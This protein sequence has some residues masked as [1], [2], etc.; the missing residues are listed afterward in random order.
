M[1][2]PVKVM[3]IELSHPITTIE[4]LSAYGF[5]KGLVRIHGEPI[6]Y[7]TVPVINGQCTPKVLGKVILEK[8]SKAIIHHLLCDGLAMSSQPG[9]LRIA[10]LFAVQHPVYRG[11]QPLVTVAV[12]TRDR[13][14]DLAR[15]L[16]SLNRLDYAN[17]DILVVDN[18]PD[19][20]DTER[21]VRTTYPN[22]RYVCEPRP[23][24][25]WARNRAIIEARGEI[26]AYTDDDVLVDPGWVKA[27]VTVFLE[28][29]EAMA[30]TGL[31][32]PYEL[33]TE[34]QIFF[35]LLG[36]FGRGFKRKWYQINQEIK[37]STASLY[38]LSWIFGTGANMAF[39]RCLFNQIGYFDPALDVGTVTNG[40]GDLEIFFRVMK[41]GYTMVYEPCALVFHCHRRDYKQLKKQING[42]GTGFC[43]YLIRSALAYPDERFSFLYIGLRWIWRQTRGLLNSFVRH[44]L[45]PRVLTLAEL[46]GFFIGP[47]RYKKALRTAAKIKRDFGPLILTTS[48]K[49]HLLRKTFINHHYPVAE[50]TIDLNNPLHALTDVLDS[51]FVRV[52]VARDG[53]ILGSVDI[54][55]YCQP[56]SVSRLREA[57]VENLTFKLIESA[58]NPGMDSLQTSV[59][60]ALNLRFFPTEDIV[61]KPDTQN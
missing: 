29:N 5:L 31:V 36:G 26:I 50:R 43:A 57:I 44:S 49:E 25:D 55:N 24:L 3:D 21:L 32:V 12:C 33:E 56:I 39:R 37:K 41:E 42:W 52:S 9:G 30:V 46:R 2:K 47:V 13:T 34:A 4:N 59:L 11:P 14:D 7:V 15:C 19:T 18:A 54:A 23:G 22:V 27:M 51:S 60:E 35:E 53:N 6:G 10:D 20:D 58:Q 17:L 38:G 16:D 28:N 8:H 1:F 40:G 48:P 61:L 45:Y